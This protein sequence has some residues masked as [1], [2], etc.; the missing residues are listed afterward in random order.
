MTDD[1]SAERI[2]FNAAAK[3]FVTRWPEHFVAVVRIHEQGDRPT[4]LHLAGPGDQWSGARAALTLLHAQM[5]MTP[6]DQRISAL[7]DELATVIGAKPDTINATMVD[8]NRF[9][10]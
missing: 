7:C 9:I 6:Y 8:N 5:V 10:P 2:A 3:V 4:D 1:V